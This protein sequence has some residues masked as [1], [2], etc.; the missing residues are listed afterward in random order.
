MGKR[1]YSAGTADITCYTEAEKAWKVKRWDNILLIVSTGLAT[2]CSS[3]LPSIWEGAWI[4]LPLCFLEGVDCRPGWKVCK[5][6]VYA[7]HTSSG[8]IAEQ[9]R[10]GLPAAWG[11]ID[12]SYLSPNY[13]TTLSIEASAASVR[14]YR[15]GA[16]GHYVGREFRVTID[17][18]APPDLLETDLAWH[19]A[20]CTGS[21]GCLEPE[22]RCTIADM[23][24]TIRSCRWSLALYGGTVKRWILLDIRRWEWRTGTWRGKAARRPRQETRTR[25]RH[26]SLSFAVASICACDGWSWRI[27]SGCLLAMREE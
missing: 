27:M 26:C 2:C 18:W 22:R 25:A 14:W 23:P 5:S 19:S 16:Y 20:V 3:F 4:C 24:E 11:E 10:W 8:F 9:K 15:W 7:W 12:C 21:H 13:F 1:T 17:T 6:W